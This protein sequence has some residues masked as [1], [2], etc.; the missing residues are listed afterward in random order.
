[1]QKHLQKSV[2]KLAAVQKR[3]AEMRCRNRADDFAELRA[4]VR[5]DTRAGEY[6]EP[7]QMVIE[8]IIQQL[9]GLTGSADMDVRM[10]P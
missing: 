10:L 6:A 3:I 9:C 8:K 4:V 2:Q 5:A 7:V 1:M